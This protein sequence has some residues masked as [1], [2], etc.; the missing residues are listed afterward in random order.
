M[1]EPPATDGRNRQRPYEWSDAV[2]LLGPYVVRISSPVAVGSG[3]LL[4]WTS[5]SNLCAIATAAHVVHHAHF[6]EEPLR[7]EH[8]A[9]GK[10]VLVR[11]HQ[12]AIFVDPV[13]DTAAI[14]IEKEEFPFP[15]GAIDLVPE[16]K[17]LRVG[18]KVGWLGFP[19]IATEMCFF[20]GSVS[21]WRDGDKA[22]LVDGVAINGVSGGPAFFLVADAP[23]LIGVVSAYIP[24]RATGE[25]L[26]GLAIVRDV[27]Q[28]HEVAPQFASIDE[29]RANQSTPTTPPPSPVESD[30]PA[31]PT[32]Y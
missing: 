15:T 19:A 22:Y 29:A 27:S 20:A 17:Y 24:N 14:V 10:S 28:F 32:K 4:S 1:T 25:V 12:R 21:A 5:K 31:T 7:I 11:Q 30:A 13:R 6:W 2:D 26:P 23:M 8:V 16:G 18:N 3:F 9:S